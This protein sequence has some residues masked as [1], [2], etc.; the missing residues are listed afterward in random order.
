MGIEL[1]VFHGIVSADRDPIK[2]DFTVDC[3]CY[4]KERRVQNNQHT[5]TETPF[6]P[7]W[8]LL[9]V[10]GSLLGQKTFRR[11]QSAKKH[12]LLMQ[13]TKLDVVRSTNDHVNDTEIRRRVF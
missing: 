3:G 11:L 4:M 2:T 12:H 8:F 9:F 5:F 7:L 10:I 13:T 6:Q 1:E